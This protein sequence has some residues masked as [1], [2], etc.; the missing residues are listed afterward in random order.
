MKLSTKGRYGTRLMLELAKRYN[1]KQPILLR[2]IADKQ[3]ISLKYLEQIIILLKNAKLVRSIRGSKGGYM[4]SK[5]PKD[6][7]ILEIIEALE[8]DIDIV[9]CIG[10]PEMCNKVESCVTR[11]V[12]ET[13]SLRI[14]DS[15]RNI[16]LKDLIN[17]LQ[18]ELNEI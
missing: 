4:L 3:D 2:Q 15:L 17:K 7:N 16:S 10:H 11:E 8:G 9:D 12:W 18:G 5:P 6:V 1:E 13:I 14:K